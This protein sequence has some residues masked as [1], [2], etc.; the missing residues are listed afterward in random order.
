[1]NK[2]FPFTVLSSTQNATFKAVM[3]LRDRRDRE[4]RRLTVLEG[5]RELTRAQEY[6]MKLKEC[7][8]APE[9]FL[10][11]NEFTVLKNLADHGVR[12]YQDY[13]HNP[14]EIQNALRIAKMQEHNRLWAVWQLL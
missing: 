5:Y 2:D 13:G 11:E 12:I 9:M 14:A 10:G 3:K 6:G 1:M 7:F 8:F 4:K